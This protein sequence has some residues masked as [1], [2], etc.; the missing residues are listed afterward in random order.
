MI[1]GHVTISNQYRKL[2]A[3]E[4]FA[5]VSF[6]L[7]THWLTGRNHAGSCKEMKILKVISLW[8]F[9]V[10]AS[11]TSTGTMAQTQTDTWSFAVSPYLWLPNVNGTSKYSIPPGGAGSPDVEFGPNDYLSNLQLALMLSGEARKGLWS[12]FTDVIYLDFASEESHVNAVDFGSSLVSTDFNLHTDS[13]LNGLA[14][15]LGGGYMAIHKPAVTLEVLGGLRYLGVDL[16]SAWQLSAVVNGPGSGQSFPATGNI[17]ESTDL[18]D[19]ITGLRGRLRLGDGAWSSLYY[20]DVGTGSSR[21]TWQ[22]LLGLDYNFD[23]GSL[24]AAYRHLYYDQ[25]DDQLLQDFSFSG[26]LLG[27]TFRF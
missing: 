24:V 18:W 22:G 11:L 16:S 26:P 8:Y 12:V 17:N 27:A 3:S 9:V 7:P 23:W 5:P 21:L 19:V 2:Q 14:W 15:T 25:G 10:I 20:I 1:Y 4:E 13:S 6:S